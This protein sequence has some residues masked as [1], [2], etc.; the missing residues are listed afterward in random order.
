[1]WAYGVAVSAQDLQFPARMD[2]IEALSCPAGWGTYASGVSP[3]GDRFLG[4]RRGSLGELEQRR[5][6][7]PSISKTPG[8]GAGR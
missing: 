7:Y 3:T 4:R 5:P 1:M 8:T 6:P 2:L